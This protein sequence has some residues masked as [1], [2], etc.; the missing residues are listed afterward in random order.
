[1]KKKYLVL[2]SAL[3]C[4][5]IWQKVD[6]KENTLP[7]VDVK[8]T[9]GKSINT[10]SITND[11]KPIIISFWATWCKPCIKELT[12]IS[13]VYDEWQEETGVKLV[14]V[15]IDDARSSS[16]VLPLAN[17]KSWDYD[18]L[19]DV[20]GD[21]K[22]AMGVNLIP[23]TFLLDGKGKIVWQHTSFSEGAELDLIEKIR[24]ISAEEK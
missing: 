8:T 5:A 3:L 15:S 17:G 9:S 19:L 22:R 13:E 1:M 14:A 21:F 10:K 24:E 2:V 6:A 4:V 11:G 20:N 16:K 12:S 7:S 18:I 23:H